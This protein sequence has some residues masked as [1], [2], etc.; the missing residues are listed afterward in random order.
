MHAIRPQRVD[1]DEKDVVTDRR[2]GR[3]RRATSAQPDRRDKNAYRPHRRH[4]RDDTV[5]SRGRGRSVVSDASVLRVALVALVIAAVVGSVPSGQARYI[6]GVFVATPQG[7]VELLAYAEPDTI[8][9]LRLEGSMDDVPTL[10]PGCRVLVSMPAW[11][12]VGAMFATGAVFDDQWSERR[13]VRWRI[14][15]LN[16]YAGEMDLIELKE[17]GAVPR[18]MKAVRASDDMPGYVFIAISNNLNR[19]G[20]G[21]VRYYPLRIDTADV[22][23]RCGE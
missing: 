2:H 7:P 4:A 6:D 15:S 14:R 3:G 20:A 12:P 11:R 18:L 16:I 22:Q 13:N 1:G 21:L 9:R 8:G 19:I 23:P 5:G 10:R 17:R